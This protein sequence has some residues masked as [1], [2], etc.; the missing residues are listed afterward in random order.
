MV[1]KLLS[2][3]GDVQFVTTRSTYSA[4][5]NGSRQ[6]LA[7]LN[8]CATEVRHLEGLEAKSGQ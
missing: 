3:G 6:A 4:A 8:E 7:N 1:M 2:V 5:V